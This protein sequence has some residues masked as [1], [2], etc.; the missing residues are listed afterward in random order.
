MRGS[1]SEYPLIQGGKGSV[2]VA[3]KF[4]GWIL[5]LALVVDPF[6]GNPP[7]SSLTGLGVIIGTSRVNL[8][9]RPEVALCISMA[10]RM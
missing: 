3:R 5:G 1:L 4:H 8:Q 9:M 6:L 2:M 7:L 10:P